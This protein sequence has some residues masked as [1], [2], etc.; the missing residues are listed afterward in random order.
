MSEAP[1]VVFESFSLN[2]KGNRLDLHLHPGE[3]LAVLGP[4]ASGKSYLLATVVREASPAQGEVRVS[5]PL[6]QVG[7][8]ESLRKQTPQS[9]LRGVLGR[10]EL[11]RAA[12]VLTAL[13]L[14]EV[15]QT[16][17]AKLSPGQ[18]HASS[19]LEC[20][21]PLGHLMLIDAELDLLDPWSM[22]SARK[23]VQSNLEKGGSLIHVTNRVS[24]AAD[25]T[26]LVVLSN[27]EPRF[28]GTPK[29]LIRR[30]GPVELVVEG[31]DLSTVKAIAAPF[32]VTAK[33]EA[34]R[35]ILASEQGQALAAKLLT[36]GYGLVKTVAVREPT[37]E[38]ALM[39]I[40]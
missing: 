33:L 22:E 28:A 11:D 9:I 18:K 31:D 20:L 7:W 5:A 16:P 39:A 14:W 12:E 6:A 2:P 27:G 30:Y 29:E 8:S 21:A 35:L 17:I 24:L 40:Y 26:T 38:E 4:S 34:G 10:G 1:A 25:A 13:G 3:S 36:Q 15:R 37:L 19:L 32:C 23:L